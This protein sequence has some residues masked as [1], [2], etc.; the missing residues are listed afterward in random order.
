VKTADLLPAT[1]TGPD[2]S[3]VSPF[4]LAVT[5]QDERV[6]SLIGRLIVNTCLAMSDPE[7]VQAP[8]SQKQRAP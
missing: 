5:E 8:P 7:R 2:L 3:E 6:C 1:I 4:P